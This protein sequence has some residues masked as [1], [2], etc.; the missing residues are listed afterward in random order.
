MCMCVCM[1]VGASCVAVLKK[2]KEV[3]ALLG[4]AV[5][6]GCEPPRVNAGN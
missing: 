3:I 5:T 2:S 6:R 1:Y 4:H